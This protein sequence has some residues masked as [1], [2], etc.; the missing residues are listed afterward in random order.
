M[1]KKVIKKKITTAVLEHIPEHLKQA[2]TVEEAMSKWW[3]NIRN[4]GG[5]RLTELG[6]MMFRLAEIEYFDYEIIHPNE[7][8]SSRHSKSWLNVVLEL[9]NKM[10][11]PYFIHQKNGKANIRIYDSKVAVLISLHGNLFSYIKATR[12]R[13]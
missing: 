7:H 5:L 12:N 3:L 6:D 10:P 2:Q 8:K 4:E 1:T 9:N 11:C 13:T